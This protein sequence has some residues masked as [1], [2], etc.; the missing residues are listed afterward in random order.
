[1]YRKTCVSV[2]SKFPG[3]DNW[4]TWGWGTSNWD[5]PWPPA[6]WRWTSPSWCHS[7]ESL[8][9]IYVRYFR[10]VM[11]KHQEWGPSTGIWWL[12]LQFMVKDGPIRFFFDGDYE[13]SQTHS[14]WKPAST[15]TWKR[16]TEC[17]GRCSFPRS[18]VPP[19]F[20]TSMVCYLGDWWS[21]WTSFIPRLKTP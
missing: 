13:I 10:L 7:G 18:T 20:G 6:T 12:K 16:L 5:K 15:N 14:L 8:L 9:V 17:W 1:M 19:C 4:M 21:N 2:V 11:E 3:I